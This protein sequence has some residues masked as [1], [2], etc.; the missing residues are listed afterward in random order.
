MHVPLGIR[1]TIGDVSEAGFEALRLSL[2]AVVRLFGLRAKYLVCVN[3]IS[4]REA[5][6]RTGVHPS[7]IGWRSTSQEA[8]DFLRP[9]LDSE[10]AEGVAWKF[11]PLRAF[12]DRHEL[13]LDNDVILWD[14]PEAIWQWLYGGDPTA[15]VIAADVTLALGKFADL[16]GHAPLN[17]GIR[18]IAPAFDFE[19]ALKAVLHQKAVLLESELD[20]QGLQAAAL[21]WERAPLVVSVE[22][23]SICSPFYPHHPEL[24]RCGAHFIGLNPL[25]LP[26]TYY[27]RPADDVRLAHWTGIATSFTD[28]QA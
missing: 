21:S 10:M 16:C 7:C 9:F 26:W 18:G 23:V 19:A 27:D 14:M 8:P 28:G 24:G 5:Q 15:C 3:S 25:S 2:H 12:P 1:W 17:S 13:A 22:D 4:V 11:V 6:Q 20:E